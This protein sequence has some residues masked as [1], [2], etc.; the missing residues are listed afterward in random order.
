MQPDDMVTLN[1]RLS[2]PISKAICLKEFYTFKQH[3][4]GT[5]MGAPQ[6]IK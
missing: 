3:P 4:D 6:I 1:K 5:M 2:Y